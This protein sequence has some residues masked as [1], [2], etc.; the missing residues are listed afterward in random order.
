M[1]SIDSVD[2]IIPPARNLPSEDF[3]PVEK[4]ILPISEKYQFGD[5]LLPGHGEEYSDCGS[6]RY[7]G[8]PNT[9]GH[10]GSLDNPK[11]QGKKFVQVYRRSCNRKECPVCYEG[12][13]SLQADRASYRLLNYCVSKK[14][15]AEVYRIKDRKVRHHKIEGIFRRA[16]RKPVHVI[17]SVPRA[18]YGL[19]Y[20]EL[21]REFYKIVKMAGIVG[22][23]VMFHPFRMDAL[24]N[25]WYFSPHF[26][27]VG[28]GWV[29]STKDIYE[30]NGW[31]VKNRGIR[32]TVHGTLLYQL[33]HAGIHK[34]H[35]VTVW[36]GKLSY[37]SLHLEP[38]PELK[39][40]CPLCGCELEELVFI[41]G[42]DRGPPLEVGEYWLDEEDWVAH[43]DYGSGREG[44]I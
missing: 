17:F 44:D 24:T 39:P 34:R 43:S 14:A 40:V 20:V 33:S 7:R 1:G 38:M 42:E 25:K 35:H 3:E 9:A 18:L 27:V 26:H 21:K 6:T 15:V 31:I 2:L 4:G 5:W 28:F 29:H 16:R 37:R 10:S 30:D 22:G 12:W 13:A 19:T 11:R 8:C 41:G 36:F 32:K 23:C